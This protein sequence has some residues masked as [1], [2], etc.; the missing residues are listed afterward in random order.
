MKELE[1]TLREL[2]EKYTPLVVNTCRKTSYR[3]A[4][5]GKTSLKPHEAAQQV[6][7]DVLYGISKKYLNENGTIPD[8][9][10]DEGLIQKLANN[11]ANNLYSEKHKNRY[12]KHKNKNTKPQNFSKFESIFNDDISFLEIE[13]DKNDFNNLENLEFF[14]SMVE[15]LNHRQRQIIELMFDGVKQEEIASKLGVSDRTVRNDLTKI[16]QSFKQDIEE[17][18]KY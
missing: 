5:A 11:N 13:D 8:A 3:F 14:N 17:S 18:I 9:G 6:M 12:T 15:S 10:I 2:R 16:R 4:V 7:N 1:R